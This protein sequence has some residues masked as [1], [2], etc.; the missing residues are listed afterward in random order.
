MVDESVDGDVPSAISMNAKTLRS[1][2][3]KGREGGG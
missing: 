2:T 3:I 1:C